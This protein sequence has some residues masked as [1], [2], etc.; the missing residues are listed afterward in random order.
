MISDIIRPSYNNNSHRRRNN[1]GRLPPFLLI[2]IF[3]FLLLLSVVFPSVC[4]VLILPSSSLTFVVYHPRHRPRS[5]LFLIVVVSLLLRSSSPPYRRCLPLISLHS[6]HTGPTPSYLLLQYLHLLL[7]PP[8]PSP[9]WC[10]DGQ[11]KHLQKFYVLTPSLKYLFK[12]FLCSLQYTHSDP[13]CFHWAN[14]S[15]PQPWSD[16]SSPHSWSSSV[17]SFSPILPGAVPNRAFA[18][19]VTY[20]CANYSSS[21]PWSSSALSWSPFLTVSIRYSAFSHTVFPTH[22]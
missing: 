2:S 6:H 16:K 15:S 18:D 21:C 9:L 10:N 4:V 17:L 22:H 19:A 8:L 20:T 5:F 7:Y 3:K 1:L 12:S 14:N 11:G 13:F